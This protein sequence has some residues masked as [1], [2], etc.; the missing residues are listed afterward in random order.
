MTVTEVMTFLQQHGDEGIKKIL[1]KHGIREP[2]FGVKI[3]HLKTIQKKV[4]TDN[5]LALDL[6]AT[7]NADA[8]YLAGLIT[9]DT[10]ISKADL[11]LWVEQALSNNIN[12]YTVPWVAAGSPYGYELALQWID[13][14]E[15]HI[16]A[17][18]WATLNNLV[19]LKAD[20]DLDISNLRALLG[21]VE[22]TIH[23]APN[24]VRL[25]M[26]SF[27]IAVGTYVVPLH[28]EAIEAARRIG[29]VTA[30]MNGTACK[31]PDPITYIGKAEAKNA[32]GKKKKMVKC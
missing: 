23:T 5:R 21:R 22:Q 14:P 32:I 9:D 24:R 4:Q 28:H 6:Y 3:E 31:V 12:E 7:G 30:D 11:Q 26:N 13:S 8:M 1:V 20:N 19:A 29:V 2:F 15:D 25:K 16:A 10:Q 27:I 17:A 18:G